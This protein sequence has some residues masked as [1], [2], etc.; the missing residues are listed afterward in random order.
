M[1]QSTDPQNYNRVV[2][3]PLWKAAMQKEYDSLLQNRLGIWF[4][5]HQKGIFSGADGS[6]GSRGTRPDRLPKDFIRSINI[7][8]SSR[9]LSVSR[10]FRLCGIVLQ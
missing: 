7:S 9:R 1:V 4:H 3:N 10:S 5:F 2:G 8:T 6:T